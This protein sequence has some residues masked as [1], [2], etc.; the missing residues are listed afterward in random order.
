MQRTHTIRLEVG[1]LVNTMISAHSLNQ[2]IK[3]TDNISENLYS[4][5][6]HQFLKNFFRSFNNND[7]I[8]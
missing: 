6:I 3:C 5:H 2:Y 8:F 4:I 7:T 1:E